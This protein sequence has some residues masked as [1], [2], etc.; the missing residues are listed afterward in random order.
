MLPILRCRPP[1]IL[2]AL[3]CA[4]VLS[5]IPAPVFAEDAISS[6]VKIEESTALTAVIDTPA[7]VPACDSA[8]AVSV[9]TPTRTSG[10]NHSLIEYSVLRL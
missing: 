4:L 1:Q 10:P 6:L 9:Q 8:I 5:R 7:G 3:L 2:V